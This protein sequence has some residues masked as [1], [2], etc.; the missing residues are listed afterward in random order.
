MLATVLFT[1]IVGSSERAAALGDRRWRDFLENYYAVARR[2]LDRFRGREIDTA[3]DGLFATFDGP[4]RAVRCASAI[5]D[6]AWQLG[7]GVRAGAGNPLTLPSPPPG[8]RT[9]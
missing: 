9:R 2:Q 5:T 3:E 4:A 6:A 8:E 7:L 1:D